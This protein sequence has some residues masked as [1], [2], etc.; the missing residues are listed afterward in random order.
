ML[1]KFASSLL[2]L[3][4]AVLTGCTAVSA[5]SQSPQLPKPAEKKLTA[6]RFEPMDPISIQ[7]KGLPSAPEFIQDEIDE[8]GKIT[9]PYIGEVTAAGRTTSQLEHDIYKAYVDG[10]IYKPTISVTVTASEK[11]Y[12]MWGEV[13]SPGR[14][15][16]TS[17]TTLLQAIASAG[18]YSP[19]A[20]EKK[21]Q[22]TRGG[23]NYFFNGREL[24]GELE[25]D[26]KVEADDVI[27]VWRSI[28]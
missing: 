20:N 27:R 23:E 10:G 19:Y 13:G 8:D 25:K 22:L 3:L 24:E 14:Y 18:G 12:F 2:V 4:C 26:P 15:P 16:L 21:I 7:I 9:L 28:L 1:K 5:T 6:H 17:G 11:Y